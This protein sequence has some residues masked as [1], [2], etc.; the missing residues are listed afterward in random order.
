MKFRRSIVI[1]SCIIVLVLGLFGFQPAFGIS[2]ESEENIH[3]SNLHRID[4]DL[5]AWGYGV[6]V[7]GFIEGDLIAGSY[8]V[9][10]NGHVRGSENVFAFRLDHKGK[11]DG[12][13]RCLV[14]FC[15]IDGYVGRSA[16]IAGGDL[17]I[18]KRA[19]IEKE[20]IINGGT[21][22]FDGIVKENLKITADRIFVSGMI[23]GDALL[24]GENISVIA[25]AVIKGDLTYISN[26][27]ANI[28]VDSG[29]TIL[30]ETT[31]ELPDAGGDGENVGSLAA[32][33]VGLAKMLAAFL[34]GIILLFLFE[35]YAL[36]SIRQL[37]NR[38]AVTTATG[39]LSLLIFSVSIV[40]L[41]VS[42]AFVLLGLALIYEDSA[43]LGVIILALSILMVPI[44]SFMTVCG[45]VLFYSGKIILALVVGYGLIRTVKS[46]AGVISR[47]QLF[48]GLIVL[49]LIFAIPYI[50]FLLYVVAS[51]VGAGAIILGIKY[52]R[53]EML[54]QPSVAA[55]ESEGAEP[56]TG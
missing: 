29:V 50:G 55:S 43:F 31:W 28:E 30:G 22:H 36:E 40:I 39:F 23:N 19:V 44:T 48:V 7:D 25:P 35:K 54:E 32:T 49:T 27:E 45:G 2:F 1:V 17:R 56:K 11:V 41:L 4:D 20:A 26:N 53:R 5:F 37:R 52:C 42:V 34:F 13:L 16:L 8:T 33:I 51:I 9:N 18:G 15:E 14:N 24:K 10:V 21:V 38:P 6:T 3:I 47:F 46:T 12:A